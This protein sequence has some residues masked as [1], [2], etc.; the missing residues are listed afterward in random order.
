MHKPIRIGD[1]TVAHE[2]S[3]LCRFHESVDVIEALGLF[4]AESIEQ[5]KQDQR[6][7]P[8]GRWRRIEQGAGAH[9]DR[10]GIVH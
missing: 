5:R 3:A 9:R 4:D 7:D 1:D 10:Q 8:L 2:E 6:G